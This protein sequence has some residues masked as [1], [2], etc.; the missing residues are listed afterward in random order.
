MQVREGRI[1]FNMPALVLGVL[2]A[3]TLPRYAFAAAVFAGA[4]FTANA[5]RTDCWAMAMALSA[6]GA[7]GKRAAFGAVLVMFVGT[8]IAIAV[9]CGAIA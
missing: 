4:V 8:A 9:A 1:Y 5:V 3:L 2:V 7:N 6:P